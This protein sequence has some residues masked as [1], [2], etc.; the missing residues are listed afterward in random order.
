MLIQK[1]SKLLLAVVAIAC[2]GSVTSFI[3]LT[4][5]RYKA[6]SPLESGKLVPGEAMMATFV[7]PTPG[8]LS[9]LQNFGT[10]ETQ[11]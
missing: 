1:K 5:Q 9:E 10:P 2:V 3:Y 8:A 11:V 4:T 7:S 6:Y